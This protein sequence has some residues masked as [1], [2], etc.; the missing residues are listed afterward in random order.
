MCGNVPVDVVDDGA[1]VI[2]AGEAHDAL[3]FKGPFHRVEGLLGRVLLCVDFQLP[4]ST[5]Q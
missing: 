5:P 2:I 1:L 4:F 3:G